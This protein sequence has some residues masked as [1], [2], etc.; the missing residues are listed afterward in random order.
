MNR[1]S[2]FYKIGAVI[3]I[4]LHLTTFGPIRDALAFTASSISYRMASGTANEGG[5][6]RA[7]TTVKLW[8]DTI[9]EPCVG[10]ANSV[11]YILNAGYIPTIQANPPT[12]TQNIPYQSWNKDA[13]KANAFGLDNYFQSPEGYVLSYSVSGNSQINVAIDSVTHVVSFTQPAGWAGVEKVTFIAE[14][15]EH[16]KTASSKVV[17][18]VTDPTA[19]DKP[20]IVEVTV[21]PP[22]IKEGDLITLT[23]KAVDPE[24]QPVNFTYSDFFIQTRTWQEGDFWY[25]EATW[26]T[27]STSRGHYNIRVT[28]NDP[29]NLTDTDTA[30]VNV[31]NF[32]HPPVLNPIPDIVVNEGD[33]VTITPSATDADNDAITFYFESPFDSQGKWLT[34]YDSAGTHFIKVTASDSID[35]V[36]QTAK[37]IV[38]N[39]N[40]T[41]QA[42]LSLDKYTVNPNDIITITLTVSDPDGDSMTFS[43][44]KDGTEIASGN[45]TDNYLTSTSFS[46]IGDHSISASV[47]DSGSLSV[48]DS[49]GVDVVDPTTQRDAINPVMGDF[50][51][52]AL[53]D[54]GLHDSAT[55]K[56]EI[57]LSDKG[58][59]RN[60]VDW[61][62]G[63][64]ASRDWWP[65]GGDFNG[66][67]KTDA[68]VYNIA[69]GQLQVAFS[70]G[71]GFISQG[72]WLTAAFAGY[73]WQPVTGNFNGDKYTDFA[74]YNR[75]TGEIKVSLGT[76]S[77]FGEFTS[78]LIGFGNDYVAMAGDFNADSLSDL[79]LF[80]K[81]SGEFK[82]AFSNTRA[83]VDGASWISGFAT[84]KDPLL[85]DFN[86][87]GFTDIGYWDKSNYNCY[88]A[89]STGAGFVD[90][91]LWLNFGSSQDESASTGDF[92]ADGVTDAAAFDRDEIGI[93]RWRV[94]LSTAQPADLLT[95][96]DNSIGGKTQVIYTY[97]AL[98]DNAELP[99]PVYVASSIS[100]M[101]TFPAD[102]AAIY[103]QNFIFSG[104][105]FDFTEREFRGFAKIKVSDPI[106]GNYAETY[107][108][109]GKPGQDG[110]LKGQIEK[111]ISYDGNAKKI[112]ETLNTYEVR[113]AG[114]EESVLGFPSLKE[115]TTAIWEENE[116]CITTRSKYTYDNIGNVIEEISEGDV[117]K[118]GDEKSTQT[119]YAQAYEAGFNRPLEALLKDKDGNTVSQKSFEYDSRGNLA[120][121]NVFIFDPLTI[122]STLSAIRYSYDSFGNLISTINAKGAAVTTAYETVFYAFPET[123]TNFLGHTI[124]Y[125][126]EAKFGA[127]KSVTDA[128]GKTSTTAYDS[129]GRVTQVKNALNQI[130]SEYSYPDF[131]TKITTNAL[132]FSKTEYID[133]IGRK[134]RTVSSGEDGSSPRQVTAEVFY[135]NRGLVDRESLPHYIDEDPAQISYIRYDYDI[136]GR[137]KK[138]ISDFPGTS[139]D[140]QSTLNYI[141]PLY[142]ETIDPQGHKKGTLKDVYG[143]VIEVTEFTQGGVYHTYYEY[144]VQS[145]L[146]KTADAQGN[147]V[148]IFYDSIGR[149]LKMIDPDMGT[150]A[151]EYDLLGN[152]IKQT[153]AKGQVLEFDYDVLNRLTAKRYPLSAN[154]A[155]EYFY[156]DAAKSNCIGRLSKVIDQSGFTEFFYDELGRE[157][158]SVKSVEGIA[159]SVERQYDVLDRLIT[160]KYPDGEAVTYTYDTNSGLLESIRSTLSAIRYVNDITYNAQGQI[161]TI[162][163]GNNVQTD[164]TYGQDLRLSRILTQSTDHSP[165][166]T[167][168]D[169][170]YQFDKNG[171]VVTLTDNLRSNIR[172]YTYDDL[173]RL[174]RAANV[175]APGGGQA[176]FDYQYDSIG[177]MVY[178]SDVGVMAYGQSAGPHAVTS[179]GGYTYQYDANG[180]MVAG[181]NKT[182]AYDA[183]NR[184]LEVNEL[185]IITSFVYDGD[186]GRV[187]I[188]R[189]TQDAQRTTIYIGSLF[190]KQRSADSVERTVKHIFAGSNRICTVDSGLSTVNYY[191]G[192]HLGSSNIITDQNGAQV[193]YCEYTPY[194]TLARNEGADLVKHKFTGKELDNTGLYFYGARYYDP[195]IGRFITADTIVQEPYNP[196]TLNRYS[197]CGNNPINYVDPTGHSWFSKF[198]KNL[199]K[200]IAGN[201]GAFIAGLVVGLFTA[202]AMGPLIASLSDAMAASGAGT[203]FWEGF[204]LGGMELGIPAFTG[205]LAGG[206]AGGHN[207][208]TALKNAAIVGGITFVTAGLIEGAYAE[209][210]QKSIHFTDVRADSVKAQMEKYNSLSL[211]GRFQEAMDVKLALMKN[212]DFYG[213]GTTD[214][215]KGLPAY[216]HVD[217]MASKTTGEFAGVKFDWVGKNNPLNWGKVLTSN[218]VKGTFSAIDRTTFGNTQYTLLLFKS[219]SPQVVDQ[220]LKIIPTFAGREGNYI[221]YGVGSYTCYDGAIAVDNTINK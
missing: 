58:V 168:Q 196:Q 66:D 87:D 34:N 28:V 115:Q 109:Q 167:V 72:T 92:N 179:A 59:F 46:A 94:N 31:G 70:T 100:L 171:N 82:V 181:K 71:S 127:V 113:K 50:N 8:Q 40:R 190:E 194:G 12:Q 39:T 118:T 11:N 140:S 86:N 215:I 105:Y 47:I 124:S 37:V 126:Y 119:S 13:A 217:V 146:I 213:F 21:S 14:D 134:Y 89:I 200:A 142:I 216:Q 219:A 103:T 163:Y 32:N 141:N 198:F 211:Q 155:V 67:G 139:K 97:A 151:Y 131:N 10:M 81:S 96:I 26:Q 154:P 192:D 156:D 3:L 33:L 130:V 206:V 189:A 16:N 195:T 221:L 56:W 68:A 197:Y 93:N 83:F 125:V 218:S 122:R 135:N 199:G 143:N 177:N 161:R 64:G 203:T 52:D 60:A 170:N 27:S 57:C 201:P 147:I 22:I 78:W 35:T 178:K 101:N 51:G 107:F 160:L 184:L 114:P 158:K 186:G 193:Q 205:T 174:T 30:L 209:G 74:L 65:I 132:G 108:Y 157:I 204:V 121:E 53:S 80:K 137:V 185:G 48:T 25:S 123:I 42:S 63:F 36:F 210:W 88:Y 44:K 144:D 98:S 187:K 159:Y 54:L 20:V 138:T 24:N 175:P 112:S 91:G 90:K 15:T 202:W 165:Q 149:K 61:L 183:E 116:S 6:N 164:Y 148:Q 207:F 73:S 79:C 17:L 117:S 43:L 7:A 4:I 76:G 208:G 75:D 104:G 49:R 111:I 188:L 62:T 23:V 19:E 191:H 145:N 153:D 173:D 172:S 133:G 220:A 212:Y 102:R 176:T 110:A 2:F 85:S 128:N 162:R 1:N 214:I 99:F 38:N 29:T 77:G 129:L 150:W 41:P 180:N 45:I 120:T 69:N 9:G 152:L 55:G 5:S 84:D 106:T 136:R 166:T 18:Q 182:M 169:L 95:E